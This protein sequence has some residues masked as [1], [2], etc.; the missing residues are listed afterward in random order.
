[1]V[2]CCAGM[3]KKA[4]TVLE[5]ARAVFLSHGFSAATTDMIQRE[6]GVSKSTVYAHYPTKDALFI[7][8]IESECSAFIASV[9]DIRFYPGGL[10]ET[11]SRLARAY[12][13]LLLSPS[14]LALFRVIIAETARFP[15]L[16]NTFYQMGPAAM[17]AKVAGLLAHAVE[18]GELDLDGIEVMEAAAV[19]V[20]LTRGE[21]QLQ[22]LTHVNSTP[23]AK[24][25]GRWANIVVT[26][27]L[28]AYGISGERC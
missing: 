20:V 19:F 25:I 27:F 1:M 16:A 2:A 15:H 17:N 10:R 7:A 21:V 14:S 3:N 8:V 12:L 28:R 13:K 26:T 4:Q 11:L 23:T 22:C 5:A 6:A 9:Q 24:Q 18:S